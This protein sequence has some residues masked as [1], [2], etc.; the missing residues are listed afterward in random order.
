MGARAPGSKPSKGN[1]TRRV[2]LHYFTTTRNARTGGGG[3]A[4][5]VAVSGAGGWRSVCVRVCG[6]LVWVGRG[7]WRGE[8]GMEGEG[9]GVRGG[10]GVGVW[11]CVERVAT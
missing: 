9:R 8:G 4:V 3:R 2:S 11:V 7:G 5:A 6:W 1:N 10:R